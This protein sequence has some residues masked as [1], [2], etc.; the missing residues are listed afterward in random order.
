MQG[1][2]GFYTP[3]AVLMQET[4]QHEALR[5]NTRVGLSVESGNESV[6]GLRIESSEIQRSLRVEKESVVVKLSMF[7]VMEKLGPNHL[8]N[9]TTDTDSVNM[10][11]K[12]SF[13]RCIT[14]PVSC[15][16]QCLVRRALY[17]DDVATLASREFACNSLCATPPRT[18]EYGTGG[19]YAM[20]ALLSSKEQG[21]I[22][23]RLPP[24]APG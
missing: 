9:H 16:H 7:E 18:A 12:V 11:C 17:N 15:P 10:Q 20:L 13:S 14:H 21:T 23:T 3:E 4:I 5:V 2:L 8:S 19:S 24:F 1:I 6:D 22:P